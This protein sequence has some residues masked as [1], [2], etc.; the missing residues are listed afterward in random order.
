MR[1]SFP[2][3]RWAAEP[4]RSRPAVSDE[5]AILRGLLAAKSPAM[6]RAVAT[7]ERAAATDVP[8]LLVGEPGTGKRLLAEAIHAWSRRRLG[9]FVVLSCA[10]AGEPHG[11]LE[12]WARSRRWRAAARRRF[13]AAAGGSMFLDGIDRLSVGMQA[14]LSGLLDDA[15]S[16]GIDPSAP[17]LVG[18]ATGNPEAAMRE[19][20]LRHDLYFR[21]SVVTVVVSPLRARPDD[22]V[23]LSDQLVAHYAARCGRVPPALTAD[24]RR[25]LASHDWPGNVRQLAAVLERAVLCAHGDTIGEVE[26][27]AYV[28]TPDSRD[29]I[30]GETLGELER[31][32][33]RRAMAES[34][35]LREAAARL[36]IDRTSLWRMRKR[37]RLE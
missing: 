2:D 17:R 4:G 6:Q 13:R 33:V 7:L 23:A 14:E 24:A 3:S 21:V 25:A 9:A 34:P 11:R 20:R 15:S 27:P 18:A 30:D 8:I 16:D 26:L 10:G 32:E 12:Q 19:G 35:T 22:L 5:Q 28:V 36:G 1:R 31:R 37:W 29:A